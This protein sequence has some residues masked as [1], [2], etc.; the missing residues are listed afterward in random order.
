MRVFLNF[1]QNSPNDKEGQEEKNGV[2][3]I[4]SVP[5]ASEIVPAE[6]TNEI[7][8]KRGTDKE[9]TSAERSSSKSSPI[10]NQ[11]KIEGAGAGLG[12]SALSRRGEASTLIPPL[13]PTTGRF[14][15]KNADH[16]R[17]SLPAKLSRKRISATTEKVGYKTTGLD[18]F[19]SLISTSPLSSRKRKTFVPAVELR[20][21]KPAVS[22]RT[23]TLSSHLDKKPKAPLFVGPKI[24][25]GTGS[26][27]PTFDEK[28]RDTMVSGNSNERRMNTLN[29]G[30][31]N[32]NR[33]WRYYD[34]R[35]VD[36]DIRQDP[37]DPVEEPSEFSPEENNP[38]SARGD[39]A[40]SRSSFAN[41][42]V[43]FGAT[44][45]PAMSGRRKGDA[46]NPEV[47]SRNVSYDA[48]AASIDEPGDFAAAL[49]HRGLEIREQDGD[50]NCLFRAISLQIY[51][52]ASMHADIR[53]S[54]MDF[55]VRQRR[56]RLYSTQTAGD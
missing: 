52:D 31:D 53:K 56:A 28:N 32:S 27:A 15:L 55:M 49:K 34:V 42:S 47:E 12:E 29:G 11:K 39:P 3:P 41:R 6:A 1:R 14:R 8:T 25:E 5:E 7:S 30:N 54:C 21:L 36:D 16:S 43:G 50:G 48:T 33:H 4:V 51:G 23:S 38:E 18:K 40:P 26:N 17:E 46:E 10:A 2:T 13:S 9:S 35:Q 20:K 24:K 22:F 44:V 19:D 45:A 37:E